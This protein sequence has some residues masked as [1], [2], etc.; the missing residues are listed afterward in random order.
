VVKLSFDP[1]RPGEALPDGII[2]ARLDAGVSWIALVVGF[3]IGLTIWFKAAALLP[4][5]QDLTTT[6]RWIVSA[7]P[8]LTLPWWMDAFPPALSYFSREIGTIIGDVYADIGRI[9]RLIASE[10]VQA[11]LASGERLVWT[12]GNSAYADTFG[13]FR[14]TPPAA[15]YAS[16]ALALAALKD[17]I[18]AQV[19][20][21]DDTQRAD[22]FAKL[23]RDK[24]RGLDAAAPA[25]KSAAEAMAADPDASAATRRAAE[26]FLR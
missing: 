26:R 17:T 4:L 15:P 16:D 24:E 12:V 8:L 21:L 7:L 1:A 23:L 14:F 19:R 5:V 6:G 25:F 3:G 20:A 11:T 18:A 2:A 13:R 9:D 22:L 10:P